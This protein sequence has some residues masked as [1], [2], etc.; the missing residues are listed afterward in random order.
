VCCTRGA[1]AKEQDGA[2]K[3]RARA[4]ERL[5]GADERNTGCRGSCA[6][7]TESPSG[8]DVVAKDVEDDDLSLDRFEAGFATCCYTV[9]RP[10]AQWLQIEIEARFCY[11]IPLR[12]L[13]CRACDDLR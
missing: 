5:S 6:R 7:T 1:R 8:A 13:L 12:F 4:S 11:C 2:Y 10:L 3:Q 9:Y